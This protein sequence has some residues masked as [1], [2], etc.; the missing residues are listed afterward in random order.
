MPRKRR[1]K[2]STGI[3]HVM[4]KGINKEKIFNQNR[5]KS[6]FKKII[7]KHLE[8]YAVEI[9]GYCIMSNHAHF[10]IRAELQTLSYFMAAILA[11]YASYYNYKHRRNGH[12]FQNRFNS[13]CIED[14]NYYWTCLRYIH[15]NPVKAGMIKNVEQYKYSSI[16]EY[17]C[18]INILICRHAMD[19]FRDK[20]NNNINFLDYHRD[21]GEE[22]FIDVKNEIELQKVDIAIRVAKRMSKHKQL[23][24]VH[25]IFEESLHREE[26]ILELQKKL[27]ICQKDAKDL[28][29]KVRN[30]IE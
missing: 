28:C 25:Q 9:Y 6:Y 29:E 3:Y 4:V 30:L 18:N 21:S 10:I 16:S 13:E 11:E 14:A 24:I 7:L 12:V 5:E 15:L 1:M 22:F 2:S 27:N 8:K 23:K 20:F 26:Y 19:L 17:L